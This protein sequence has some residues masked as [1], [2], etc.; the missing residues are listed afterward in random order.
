VTS[1]ECSFISV[2]V[3]AFIAVVQIVSILVTVVV[4]VLILV[5]TTVL[6]SIAWLL[7][8]IVPCR[9]G[10]EK[11]TP[12]DSN[13]LVTLGGTTPVGLSQDNLIELLP[14]GDAACQRITSALRDAIQRVHLLQLEFDPS[15]DATFYEDTPSIMLAEALLGANNIDVPVRILLNDNVLVSS[16]SAVSSF[17]RSQGHNTVDVRG[18]HLL[19]EVMHAKV[20]VIDGA[21]AFIIGLPFTQGY[22]DTP[23]HPVIDPLHR[24]AGAGGNVTLLGDN[25]LGDVGNGV[26]NKPVHTVSL[27][28]AGPA[29]SDIDATFISLWNSVGPTVAPLPRTH[30]TG[31]QS[32]QIVRTAPP[33]AATG[34]A[35]GEKGTLEAYLRAIS[36][37]RTFIYMEEQYLTYPVI[38]D[39]L[40]NALSSN[41]SLQL[42]LLLNE[43]PDQPT[44]KL[45]QNSLLEQLAGFPPSQVGIFALWRTTPPSDQGLVEIMQCYV[46][47]KVAIV[48]DVWATV[49]SG[50]LDGASLSHIFE[51]LPSPALCASGSKGWRNVELGAVLYDGVGGQPATGAV[52]AIRQI[53]WAEHLGTEITAQDP[54]PAPGGWLGLWK[55]TASQNLTSLNT[56]QTMPGDPPSHILPYSAALDTGAQLTDIGINVALFN[57]A[58]A[59]PQ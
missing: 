24:G 1:I 35:G 21:E 20:L 49:G 55:Q 17:F 28:I 50:N 11:P 34:L 29:A 25:I 42:I 23:L 40:V 41:S 7:C 14:D 46:E 32:I 59:V 31:N 51:L 6:T 9:P 2:L 15:F 33:L 13:W 19:P 48:D 37:A 56:S 52:A 12:P 27:R 38:G 16:V 58:P 57:V 39:A 47:A 44:Y 53:L 5:V 3:K 4:S 54:P 10:T 22:W 43:N 36:N 45:W 18:L 30:G 8:I 26:G